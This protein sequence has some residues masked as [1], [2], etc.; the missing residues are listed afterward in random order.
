MEGYYTAGIPNVGYI[1]VSVGWLSLPG[2]STTP[3]GYSFLFL[4]KDKEATMGY[5]SVSGSWVGYLR[6]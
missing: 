3:S 5:L 1:G 4:L 2:L 6:L